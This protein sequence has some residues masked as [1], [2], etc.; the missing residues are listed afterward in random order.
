MKRKQGRTLISKNVLMKGELKFLMKIIIKVTSVTTG[1]QGLKLIKIN[2]FT[3]SHFLVGPFILCFLF[4]NFTDLWRTTKYIWMTETIKNIYRNLWLFSFIRIKLFWFFV[5]L[6]LQH[7][8]VLA[9]NTW[10]WQK[11]KKKENRKLF[12]HWSKFKQNSINQQK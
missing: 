3:A 7:G 1:F 5:N 6:Q 4:F 10:F 12:L 8:P 2:S 9:K 11:R